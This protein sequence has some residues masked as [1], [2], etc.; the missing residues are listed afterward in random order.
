MLTQRFTSKAFTKASL[1]HVAAQCTKGPPTYGEIVEH[2]SAW[3][4]QHRPAQPRLPA[5]D[6]P[7]RGTGRP[8]TDDERAYVR[9]RVAELEATL[10]SPDAASL[11]PRASYLSPEQLA[12]IRGSKP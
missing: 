7:V 6:E 5:P 9:A 4:K 12:K 1:E 11:R 10:R 3:W 2:L 8:P